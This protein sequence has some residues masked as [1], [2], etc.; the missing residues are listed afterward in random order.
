[1]DLSLDGLVAVIEDGM[2]TELVLFEM[3]AR[4]HP[5]YTLTLG[6]AER[7][8]LKD[9]ILRYVLLSTLSL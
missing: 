1:M 4:V 7:Q 6:D 5:Q 9:Y 8:R 3:A 2:A